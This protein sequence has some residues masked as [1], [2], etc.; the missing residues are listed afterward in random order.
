MKR[1]LDDR[2][3]TT[4][5]LRHLGLVAYYR[6]DY[7]AAYRLLSES[8]AMS[9][10][11]GNTWAIASSLNLLSTAAYAQHAYREA[12]DLLREALVLSQGLGDR[13]N[14]AL[15]LTGLGQVSQVVGDAPEAQRFFEDSTRIWRE[16]GDQGSLAQTL[17]QLGLTLLAQADRPEARRCFLEALRVARDAQ[18]APVMLDALLGVAALR[19]GAG[20]RGAALELLLHVYQHPACAQDTRDRAEQLRAELV[21]QLPANHAEAIQARMLGAT[22]D[23]LTQTLLA[24]A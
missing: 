23:A 18:I 21:T 15:A 22:L 13:F 19:A 2:W 8:L 14:I 1:A 3:G 24:A 20:D 9:R 7:A 10:A 5:C 16:I 12:H 17:N 11:M 6:G 4:F